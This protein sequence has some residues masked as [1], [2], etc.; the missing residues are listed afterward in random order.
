MLFCNKNQPIAMHPMWSV[1]ILADRF[2]RNSGYL[3]EHEVLST[4]GCQFPSEKGFEKSKNTEVCLNLTLKWQRW[5]PFCHINQ[6]SAMHLCGQYLL[7]DRFLKNSG[8]L[9]EC[10]LFS[11]FGCQFPSKTSFEK[12][13]NTKVC[14]Y[15]SLKWQCLDHFFAIKINL[16]Q[17]VYVV[18]IYWLIDFKGTVVTWLNMKFSRLLGVSFHPNEIS[19]NLKI[20]KFA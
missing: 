9:V 7:A 5:D 3:V 1:Y 4:L 10:E 20:P 19:G 15:L 12:S 13:K 17:C 14:L 11:T 2:L 16:V 18:N 8:Y 6:P